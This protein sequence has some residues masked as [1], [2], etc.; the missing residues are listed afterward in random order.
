MLHSHVSSDT[1]VLGKKLCDCLVIKVSLPSVSTWM[2]IGYAKQGKN[3]YLYSYIF[4]KGCTIHFI[5]FRGIVVDNR[6]TNHG[7]SLVLLARDL[8]WLEAE[9]AHAALIFWDIQANIQ[10]PSEERRNR[11]AWYFCLMLWG[12]MFM[13]HS[14]MNGTSVIKSY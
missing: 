12:L 3:S 10:F 2:D 4:C 7:C 6:F 1:F 5:L 14:K 11:S 8:D 9:W 13:K